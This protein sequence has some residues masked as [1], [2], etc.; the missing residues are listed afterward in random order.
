MIRVPATV[1]PRP[2]KFLELEIVHLPCR[3][4]SVMSLFRFTYVVLLL[5]L[6]CE[7][8]EVVETIETAAGTGA[9]GGLVRV[10]VLPVLP[11]LL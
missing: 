7:S 6:D 4:A 10:P 2:S 9:F 8:D 1:T 5:L 11:M 3:S